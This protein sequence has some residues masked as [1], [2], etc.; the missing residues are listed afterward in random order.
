[1]IVEAVKSGRKQKD[2]AQQFHCSRA[3]VC[4]I[5]KKHRKHQ[6]LE[7]R[8]KSGRPR[9]TTEAL[10]RINTRKSKAGV[11][12]NA[13]EIAREMAEEFNVKVSRQ[14]IGRRLNAAGLFGRVPIKKPWISQG[15]VFK[16]HTQILK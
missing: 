13:V 3:A 1:M 10:D 2:V 8:K 9:K 4:G 12:K 14:T 6:G 16:C 11:K 15:K 7:D 5:M